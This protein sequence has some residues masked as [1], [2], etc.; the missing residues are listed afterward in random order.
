MS[1]DTTLVLKKAGLSTW[2]IYS[3]KGIELH[4]LHRCSSDVEALDAAKAWASS[5]TSVD[6]KVAENEKSEKRN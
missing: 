2:I 3:N 5:W 6:I 4:T 1:Y